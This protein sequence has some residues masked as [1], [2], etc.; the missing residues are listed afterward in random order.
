[1]T[2]THKLVFTA[3]TRRPGGAEEEYFSAA[4]PAKMR[5]IKKTIIK[6]LFALFAFF[7]AKDI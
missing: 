2:N 1:V 6:L 3:E 5:K 7:A 4:K